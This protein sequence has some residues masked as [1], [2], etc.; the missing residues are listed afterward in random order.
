MIITI[1]EIFDMVVMIAFVGYIFKDIFISPKQRDPLEYYT[2]SRSDNFKFAIMVT[3]PAILLHELG[4]K[5]V[6]ISFG[7]QATFHAAYFWLFIGLILKMLN[8]GFIFFVPAF[9][10]ISG[11]VSAF[12]SSMIAVAGPFVNLVMWLGAKYMVKNKMVKSKNVPLF[13]LTSKINMFLFFFNMLPIPP[14]D[15]FHFFSA[16]FNIL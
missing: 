11:T 12:Q 7:A 9:V 10:T 8:F 14:F 1:R 3:A 16:L 15:G 5:F 2:K 6:A 13:L 4:H